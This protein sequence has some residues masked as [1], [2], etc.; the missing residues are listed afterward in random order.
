MNI[1]AIKSAAEIIKERYVFYDANVYG[2]DIEL[3]G[4]EIIELMEQYAEQFKAEQKQSAGVWVKASERL[5][6]D[7]LNKDNATDILIWNGDRQFAVYRHGEFLKRDWPSH[8]RSVTHWM[9][10]PPPPDETPQ[11]QVSNEI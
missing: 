3:N 5:P 1:D 6:E 4:Q 11:K 9:P 7:Q 8:W 2:K 10:L